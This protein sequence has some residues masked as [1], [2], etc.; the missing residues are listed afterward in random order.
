M[1]EAGGECE[2]NPPMRVEA[3]AFS[4]QLF[5]GVGVSDGVG[6]REVL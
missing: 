4:R 1:I 2:V 6:E 5:L 3:S